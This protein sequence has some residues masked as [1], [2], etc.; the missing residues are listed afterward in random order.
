MGAP[1]WVDVLPIENGDFSRDRYVSL[2]KAKVNESPMIAFQSSLIASI[3]GKLSDAK[4]IHIVNR[5]YLHSEV[6]RRSRDHQL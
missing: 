3:G 2:P 1:E 6:A 5:K 4:N